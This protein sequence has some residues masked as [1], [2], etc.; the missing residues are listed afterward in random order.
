MLGEYSETAAG[1][2]HSFTPQPVRYVREYL[3]GSTANSGN[4][5]VEIEVWGTRTTEFVGNY[6]EWNTQAGTGTSY[7]YAGGTRVA[8]RRNGAVM[9]IFARHGST[10]VRQSWSTRRD[11]ARP[12]PGEKRYDDDPLLG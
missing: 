7:Y 2:T 4:H 5:W 8:M 11:D 10:D 9:S 1:K 3:N 6:Y 12:I